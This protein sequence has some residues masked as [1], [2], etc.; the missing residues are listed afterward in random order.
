MFGLLEETEVP[1]EN[2]YIH[3]EHAEIHTKGTNLE[4]AG[5]K[6]QPADVMAHHLP[7]L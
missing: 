4:Q 3:R 6:H 1:R 5:T 7:L 2:L